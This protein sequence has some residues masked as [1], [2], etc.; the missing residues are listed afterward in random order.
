MSRCGID[1]TAPRMGASTRNVDSAS[2]R[3]APAEP[4]PLGL[5][6]ETSV[7]NFPKS[8]RALDAWSAMDLCVLTIHLATGPPAVLLSIC[9]SRAMAARR[10]ATASTIS[11]EA[12]EPRSSATFFVIRVAMLSTMSPRRSFPA[13]VARDFHVVMTASAVASLAAALTSDPA[14]V[15]AA[16][17]VAI[18]VIRDTPILASHPA[19]SL[20]AAARRVLPAAIR[21]P[22]TKNSVMNPGADLMISPIL[23]PT[24][25]LDLYS[26]STMYSLALMSSSSVTGSPFCSF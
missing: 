21:P 19:E 16:E 7:P 8:M 13:A 3:Y 10:L 2:P 23:E 24:L 4:S 1:M 26:C 17:S 22:D 11:L 15:S 18:L 5:S 14:M 9:L 20:P 25:P 6:V 12:E